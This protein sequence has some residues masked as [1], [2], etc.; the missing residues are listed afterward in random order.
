MLVSYKITGERHPPNTHRE[1][2]RERKREIRQKLTDGIEQKCP[3]MHHSCGFPRTESLMGTHDCWWYSSMEVAWQ[4]EL[5]S[6]CSFTL[7]VY[8]TIW[9]NWSQQPR[10]LCSGCKHSQA[11]GLLSLA[12]PS[13][14]REWGGRKSSSPGLCLQHS[15]EPLFLKLEIMKGRDPPWQ[16]TSY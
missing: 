3:Q 5:S 13:I 9:E 10:C 15:G 7:R 1:S 12:W 16:N 8:I 2:E 6:Y 14:C 4:I 11:L